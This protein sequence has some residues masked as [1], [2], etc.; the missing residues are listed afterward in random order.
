M[1]T[2][3]LNISSIQV[4]PV[5]TEQPA[6]L[7]P[8]NPSLPIQ[9]WQAPLPAGVTAIPAGLVAYPNL[10]PQSGALQ[11]SSIP[12][13]QYYSA[14]VPSGG[15]STQGQPPAPGVNQPPVNLTAYNALA[16]ENEQI[17]ATPFGLD[18]VSTAPP[19]ATV[20]SPPTAQ[21]TTDSENIQAS[22][23]LLQSFAPMLAA[24]EANVAKL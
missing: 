16:G 21:Q 8:Y 19:V 9:A 2:A 10:N 18:L 11:F 3:S 23:A 15:P 7:P 12:A 20:P 1:S 13:A 4:F 14:N 17:I 5:L 22:L 24:I 6:G